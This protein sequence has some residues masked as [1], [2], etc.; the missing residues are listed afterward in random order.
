MI[1]EFRVRDSTK[2]ALQAVEQAAKDE[3]LIPEGEDP[4]TFAIGV[5]LDRWAVLDPAINHPPAG[6]RCHLG[7]FDEA[8]GIECLDKNALQLYNIAGAKGPTNANACINCCRVL[9]DTAQKVKEAFTKKPEV[10]A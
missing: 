4:V 7:L 9:E 8:Q 1:D 6:R 3:G 10:I 5:A 2:E